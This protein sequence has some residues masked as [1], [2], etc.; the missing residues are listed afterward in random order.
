[1]TLTTKPRLTIS[2][3]VDRVVRRV[4]RVPAAGR[5]TVLPKP[6]NIVAATATVVEEAVA[7]IQKAVSCKR[8]DRRGKTITIQRGPMPS[9]LPAKKTVLVAYL[10]IDLSIVAAGVADRH[11]LMTN[12]SVPPLAHQLLPLT[13]ISDAGRVVEESR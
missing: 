13:P 5:Q 2:A 1:M 3:D 6:S 8:L 11:K 12:D 10:G 9:D 4:V 7:A